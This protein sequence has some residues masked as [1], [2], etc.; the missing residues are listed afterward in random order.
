MLR[1]MPDAERAS[2]VRQALADAGLDI[3]HAFDA[4]AVGALAQAEASSRPIRPLA[5]WAHLSNGPRLGLLVG[6]TRALWPRFVAARDSLPERN[7]L[8]T[9]VEREVAR[10]M[11]SATVESSA[12]AA[13]S[14]A[15]SSSVFYS[16]RRYDSSFLPFQQLAVVT[17]L[18]AMSDGGLAIHPIYGPWFALRAVI[19]LDAANGAVTDAVVGAPVD[20]PAR[21]PI[22]KPC[23]CTGACQERLDAAFADMN[24]WRAWLAVRDAC[25][26]REW[27]YSD[28][29]IAFHYTHAWPR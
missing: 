28:E 24:N 14:S 22:A 2:H 5:K 25:S 21:S 26:L 19:V 4:H 7:P 3:V 6:N 23:A 10:A 18:A 9:Y 16:H 13:A 29:Q 15:Q 1:A 11:A 17:G 12:S 27:R 8:D 20:V